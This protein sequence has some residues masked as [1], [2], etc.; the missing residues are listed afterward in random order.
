[1]RAYFTAY[2]V[3]LG[4]ATRLVKIATQ[5]KDSGVKI[6]F[7]SFGEASKI[8]IYGRIRMSK[9]SSL[10]ITLECRRG[11]FNKAQHCK[12]SAFIYQLLKTD[13]HRTQSDD[14]V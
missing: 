13:K 9:G 4:H 1:M 2:G 12:A 14:L 5:L 11:L 10:R 6:K 3:G 7:S 8:H